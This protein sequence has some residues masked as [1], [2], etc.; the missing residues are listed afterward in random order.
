MPIQTSRWPNVLSIR[1]I[2]RGILCLD[3]RLTSWCLP[4]IVLLIA[5]AGKEPKVVVELSKL[6]D[7][8]KKIY[9]SIKASDGASYQSDLIKE[10]GMSKVQITRILDKLEAKKIIERKRRGMTNIVVLK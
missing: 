6:D 3:L 10:L 9:A 5:P 8:E 7:D 2:S 4:F 1:A